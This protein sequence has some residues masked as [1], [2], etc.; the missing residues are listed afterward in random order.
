MNREPLKV[1]VAGAMVERAERAIPVMRALREAGITITH[2]WTT[3]VQEYSNAEQSDAGVP[4]DIRYRC[5]VLDMQGVKDADLVLLLAANERGSSGSW[6]EFGI[7]IGRGVPVIVAGEKARR[8]IF[9]SLAREIFPSD[10][11]AVAY[12]AARQRDR[13]Q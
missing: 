3:D 5:A 10:A 9:T 13:G 4:D 1:Y 8:T 6:V 11:E 7:A 12:L 2:D